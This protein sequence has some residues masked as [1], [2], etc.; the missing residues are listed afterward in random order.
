MGGLPIAVEGRLTT[1]CLIIV[2]KEIVFM[3]LSC[4]IG[5]GISTIAIALA[6]AVAVVIE[7]PL[8]AGS[9]SNSSLTTLLY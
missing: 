5:R 3:I 8:A 9:I 7:L 4:G 6:A 1:P 2:F